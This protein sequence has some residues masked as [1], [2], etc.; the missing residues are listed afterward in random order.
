[1]TA[2][3]HETSH[4]DAMSDAVLKGGVTVAAGVTHVWDMPG[5]SEGGAA[6]VLSASEGARTRIACL[7][8]SGGVLADAI[9]QGDG[10][11]FAVTFPAKTASVMISCLGR[12][13][14]DGAA[15]WTSTTS[16]VQVGALTLACPQGWVRVSAP[17][18]ARRR[19]QRA[20]TGMVRAS[21]V[22]AGRQVETTLPATA[23]VLVVMLDLLDQRAADDGD[24]VVAAG[25]ATL[26][27][28]IQVDAPR[29]RALI[30]D[31]TAVDG[32]AT[33]FAI[34]VLS[35]A[36]W[37]VA[38]TVGVGGRAAEWAA[39]FSADVP[40]ELVADG[41]GSPDGAIVIA[42]SPPPP[43]ADDDREDDA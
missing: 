15:G 6:T 31:V 32:N 36:A 34:A 30:Y 41:P 28:P 8:R 21:E 3:S 20:P 19:G 42:M 23:T 2:S 26:G 14:A 13:P 40:D 24:L 11:G 16:L 39:R 1:M 18:D 17:T 12:G 9:T 5:E 37:Q 35:T 4:M 22:V 27:E 43:P 38:G 29:Q 7:S 25:G 33:S 10:T